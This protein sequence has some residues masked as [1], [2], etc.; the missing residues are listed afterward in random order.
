MNYYLDVSLHKEGS[1]LAICCVDL[2]WERQSI[3]KFLAEETC[4]IDEIDTLLD[5]DGYFNIDVDLA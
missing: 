4:I 5:V 3:T 1:F 2:C